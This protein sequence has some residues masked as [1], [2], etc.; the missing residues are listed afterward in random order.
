MA[1][2]R[3][4]AHRYIVTITWRGNTGSGTASYTDYGRDFSVEADG[5]V[6]IDG[7]ADP[8][9]RGDPA[10]WNPEEMLVAS[11]SACHQ[12]WYLHLCADAGITV[13]AYR[14]AAEGLMRL[15]PDGAGRFTSV[16]LRPVIELAAGA[17]ATLAASLHQRAHE[18][19]FIA[20]SVGFP[21]QIEAEIH[22]SP[23]D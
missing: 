5:K 1:R 14:D 17:D 19:C 12:L 13:L 21:I 23:N 8:V 15:Q 6:E 3:V 2:S 22:V 16:M 4:S 11:V 9:F 18:M 10:R 20:N 7:S